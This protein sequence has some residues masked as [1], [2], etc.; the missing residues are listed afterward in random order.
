MDGGASLTEL[1]DKINNAFSPENVAGSAARL[2][3]L[4]RQADFLRIS[5]ELGIL[6]DMNV[7]TFRRYRENMT[8][9]PVIRQ[10]LTTIH[11][12]VLFGDSPVPMRMEINDATPPSIEVTVTDQLISVKLNRPAPRRAR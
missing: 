9:P 7:S 3:G 8:I 12:A 1:V 2:R 4:S 6:P 11:R 5:R 10:V